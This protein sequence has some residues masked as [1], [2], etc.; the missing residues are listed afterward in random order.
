MLTVGFDLFRNEQLLPLLLI[1]VAL[2]IQAVFLSLRGRIQK[3]FF[4]LILLLGIGLDLRHL[5][6][7]YRAN[8][9]SFHP[10]ERIY[11]ILSD[12]NKRSG[13][14]ALLFDLKPDIADQTLSIATYRF[15][16]ARNPRIPMEEAK[17]T[18]VLV[19]AH[20]EP[21]LKKRFP[22]GEWRKVF[23]E[24]P[25]D[26]SPGNKWLLGIIP[27]TP[28]EVDE[29]LRWIRADR[30]FRKVV[31]KAS[32]TPDGSGR[33]EVFEM[34][35]GLRA[36]ARG[37]RLLES[38]Y[39]EMVFE[40]HAW[41]SAFGDRRFAVHYAASLEALRNAIQEGYPTA[42]FYNKLGGLLAIGGDYRGARK[43]F[44]NAIGSEVNYTQASKHL[45]DL[46]RLILK[47]P[48]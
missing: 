5:E 13:P 16:A 35:P 48:H 3:W 32:N 1:V 33:K 22:D 40:F 25:E 6:L 42:D 21:F 38:L 30:E 9:S 26:H 7:I 46:N 43:A 34:L 12:K 45:S 36:S 31:W 41:E 18:A 17:W 27:V 2:G 24:D 14:G 47:P 23:P 20:Y 11:E 37:D 29:F 15:N 8:T 4:T 44:S 10:Y 19:N 28:G 39:G